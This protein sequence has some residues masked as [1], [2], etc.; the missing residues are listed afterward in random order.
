MVKTFSWPILAKQKKLEKWP[1]FDH[2][3]G[4]TP[5]EKFQFYDFLKFLF[6]SPRKPFFRSKIS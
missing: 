3:H 4:L 6:L 1:V 5:L 2:K